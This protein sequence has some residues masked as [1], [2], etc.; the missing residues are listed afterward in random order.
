M[1]ILSKKDF[2][3]SFIQH[4]CNHEW[5]PKHVDGGRILYVCQKCG[6]ALSE[7]VMYEKEFDLD[8]F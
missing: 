8:K 7:E 2:K 6:K 5:F 4:F 1:K 3:K